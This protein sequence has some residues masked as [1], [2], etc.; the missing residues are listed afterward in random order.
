LIIAPFCGRYV[1][2]A[3]V[4][5]ERSL[6]VYILVHKITFTWADK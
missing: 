3:A 2:L 1:Q 4:S 5:E 6:L